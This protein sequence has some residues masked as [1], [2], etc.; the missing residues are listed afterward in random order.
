MSAQIGRRTRRFGRTAAV[1]VALLLTGGALLVAAGAATPALPGTVGS[2]AVPLTITVPHAYSGQCSS[3]TNVESTCGPGTLSVLGYSAILVGVLGTTILPGVAVHSLPSLT[4]TNETYQTSTVTASVWLAANVTAGS[5]KIW[6]NLTTAEHGWAE[7]TLDVTN[8]TT[9]PWD[10]A[11]SLAKGT[12]P[13]SASVTTTTANDIGVL[14][15]LC[16]AGASSCAVSAGTGSTPGTGFTSVEYATTPYYMAGESDYNLSNPTGADKLIVGQ[17]SGT[18]YFA[19]AVALKQAT[20]PGA[21]TNFKATGTGDGQATLS[22]TH[23]PGPYLNFTMGYSAYL[24]GT[25][26]AYGNFRST[27]GA[28]SYTYSHLPADEVCFEVAQWNTSGEGS[29]ATLTNVYVAELLT[30]EFTFAPTNPQA[31][32][33]VSFVGQVLGGVAPYA[34]AWAFGDGHT[35][36]TGTASHAFASARSYGVWFNVT[37]AVGTKATAE[38]VVNVSSGT[39]YALTV[40]ET[41]LAA[42][43]TWQV[44]TGNLTV[45]STATTVVLHLPNGTYTWVAASA[46]YVVSPISGSLTVAGSPLAR[47]VTF[48]PENTTHV[49]YDNTTNWDNTTKTY[50]DNT[51]QIH[52]DNTTKTYWENTTDNYW[53]NT[54][55]NYW[56]N[57]TRVYYDNT[58]YWVNTTRNYWN[59]LT[60][61][62][63]V[64][65][66]YWVNTTEPHWVN[67]TL[68]EYHNA[69]SYANETAVWPWP[70]PWLVVGAG[71][72]VGILLAIFCYYGARAGARPR[73][74]ILGE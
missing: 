41:G 3:G 67:S 37:D 59:N 47:T 18:S 6:Y 74:Q 60:E 70:P 32:V 26:Q 29:F 27:A 38:S 54:T 64:N 30:A 71:I 50:W 23:A 48:Y 19:I 12:A 55:K 44:T 42:G 39:A 34:Y 14:F 8:T 40:T 25:C 16:Y 65:S 33:A 9:S 52:Y 13:G 68:L 43:W 22:W 28:E 20:V 66:T 46:A 1:A 49:Y 24:N 51:T 15:D 61:P 73:L 56:A 45:P 2:G 10:A 5:Y 58:T 4:W 53:D 62:H 17:M 57:T 69:T 35:A 31:L 63:W 21:P 11:G 7:F 72:A 36:N